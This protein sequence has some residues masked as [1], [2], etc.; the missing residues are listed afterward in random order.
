MICEYTKICDLKSQ[1]RQ[2]EKTNNRKKRESK[3]GMNFWQAIFLG[4]VQGVTE[5][6][7]VSSSAHIRI[8]GALCGMP[9]PGAAF[10]AVIQLGTETAVILYFRKDN[11]QLH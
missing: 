2:N 7:P 3:R 4:F 11:L 1:T 6:L 9:D 5:F 8:A 10:T